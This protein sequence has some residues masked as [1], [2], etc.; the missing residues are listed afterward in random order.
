MAKCGN[1]V[2]AW[3]SVAISDLD[4]SAWQSVIISHVDVFWEGKVR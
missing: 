3:P 4:V 2:L 1:D